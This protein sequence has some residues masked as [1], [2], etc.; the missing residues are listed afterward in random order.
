MNSEQLLHI[1]RATENR[2]DDVS[3][4][5]SVYALMAWLTTAETEESKQLQRY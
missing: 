1:E 3:E 5:T 2:R 4:L